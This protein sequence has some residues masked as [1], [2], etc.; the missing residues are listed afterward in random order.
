MKE[1]TYKNLFVDWQFKTAE[2]DKRFPGIDKPSQ[3][4]EEPW[5]LPNYDHNKL[6]ADYQRSLKSRAFYVNDDDK[7]FSCLA[8]KKTKSVKPFT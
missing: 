7:G 8:F 1:G 2:W 4:M 3:F 5:S 6:Y